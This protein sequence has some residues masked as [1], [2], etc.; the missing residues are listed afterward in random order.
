[1]HRWFKVILLIPLITGGCM[2]HKLW[3]ESPLDEW[4]EPSPDVHLQVFRVPQPAD[5]LV[6]YDELSD[7]NNSVQRRA[8]FLGVNQKRIA[9]QRRPHFAKTNSAEGLMPVPLYLSTPT[10]PPVFYGLTN[11]ISSEK[12]R[13]FAAGQPV[14]TFALPVY[15]DGW[16]R[17]QKIIWTP[18][19]VTADLTIIGG[20]LGC[21]WLY[22][23]G[24]G[25][26]P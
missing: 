11:C 22:S 8:F 4:N 9:E 20:C 17:V 26:S 24:V 10:N 2:T 3:T 13:L 23:G 12:I 15:A 14:D 7:R 5:W 18:V 1:M 16:G 6:V 21:I 25:I 19:A